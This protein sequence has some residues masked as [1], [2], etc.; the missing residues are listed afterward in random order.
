MSGLSGSSGLPKTFE[1]KSNYNLWVPEL[2]GLHSSDLVFPKYESLDESPK[3]K[4]TKKTKKSKKKQSRPLKRHN[5]YI[6]EGYVLQVI[7]ILCFILA[8]VKA[9]EP[10][11][12]VGFTLVLLGYNKNAKKKA[13]VG[14]SDRLAAKSQD[15]TDVVVDL[16]HN[17]RDRSTE[18]EEDKKRTK[19][20]HQSEKGEEVKTIDC[21][22]SIE[23]IE[24]GWELI[25]H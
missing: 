15:G 10:L 3:T 20:K 12:G 6:P 17:K 5:Q 14:R 16:R 9:F 23:E 11:T 8:A 2:A 19:R 25:S 24:S 18:K 1:F 22:E 4:K 7:G 13:R 21:V